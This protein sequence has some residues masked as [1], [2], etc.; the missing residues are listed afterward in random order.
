MLMAQ[1]S[2]AGL[3]NQPSVQDDSL[4][5]VVPGDSASSLLVNKIES[6]NPQVG[7]RMPLFGLALS[8][9]EINLIKNWIDQGALNN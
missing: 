9:S 1:E 6:S 2:F 3:V 5:L 7:V 8:Q 4:T